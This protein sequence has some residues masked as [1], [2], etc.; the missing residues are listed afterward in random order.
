MPSNTFA[1][2]Y[3]IGRIGESVIARWL[4]S[5]G[6]FVLPVYEIEVD[7]GK[8]PRLLSP[9]RELIAPDMFIFRVSNGKQVSQFIEAKHKTVFTWYR[10]GRR[11]TTGIDLRHYEHYCEVDRLSP[12]PVWLLFLHRSCTP[13]SDDLRHGCPS[14]CPT[15]LYAEKLSKLLKCESHRSDRHAK[16]MVYWSE[17]DLRKLSTLD[18]VIKIINAPS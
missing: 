16:G 1:E 17:S 15:G 13:S 2:S 4:R 9:D 18:D 14:E 11:W 7:S 6:W 3:E 12:W 5:R 8:G 10:I